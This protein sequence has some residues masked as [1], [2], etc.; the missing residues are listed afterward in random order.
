MSPAIIQLRGPVF[1]FNILSATSSTEGVIACTSVGGS[2]RR[3]MRRGR[4]VS[5]EGGWDEQTTRRRP[6]TGHSWEC[7]V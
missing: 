2:V 5:L 6:C 4:E 7:M 3:V 1:S